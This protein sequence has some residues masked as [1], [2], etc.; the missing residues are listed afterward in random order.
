MS[1]V[2]NFSR[3]EQFLRLVR[4]ETDV[5]LVTAALEI[6]RDRQ[7]DLQFGPVRDLLQRAVS[8]LTHPVTQAGSDLEEL[9]LLVRYMTEEL[10]LHGEAAYL[11]DP[12]SHYLHHVL[13][14]GRGIPI[15]LSVLYLYVAN[16][17]GIPLQPISTPARFLTR[18]QTDAGNLYV[19]AFDQ[20][21]ILTEPEC[22]GLIRAITGAPVSEV[23]RFLRP[24]DE[25]SIVIR[26]LQNLKTVYGS[27]EQWGPAWRVQC[28]LKML[29]PASWRERRDHAILTLRSGRVGQAIALLQQGLS[30]CPAEDRLFL[31]NHLQQAKRMLPECN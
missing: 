20:G 3:D 23:R 25:R 22:I 11:S 14:T 30:D 8:R 17:L 2:E 4:R 27:Q 12:A 15:S 18:L 21:R 24:A 29:L 16:E 6:A 19:D 5:D 10:G 7:P 26:M 13:E 31:E 1:L 28:R 9:K